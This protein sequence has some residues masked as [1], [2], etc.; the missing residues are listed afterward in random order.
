[1]FWLQKNL[2]KEKKK[3]LTEM[4]Y[5]LIKCGGKPPQVK[6]N[7]KNPDRKVAVSRNL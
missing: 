5:T 1:M 4:G 7:K 3:K 2:E 6:T